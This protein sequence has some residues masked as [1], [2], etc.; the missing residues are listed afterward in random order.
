M[1]G[2][3]LSLSPMVTAIFLGMVFAN[4]VGF[5]ASADAGICVAGKKLLRLAVAMLGLQLTFNQLA[6][7]GITGLMLAATVVVSTL[8]FTVWVGRCE[9]EV[10]GLRTLITSR[11]R[12]L[13]RI[14]G[15]SAP[16][17]GFPS[18]AQLRIVRPRK[19]DRMILQLGRRPELR[20]LCSFFSLAC[21]G[22]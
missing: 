10:P 21:L 1:A 9:G 3:V 11:Q 22:R 16:T 17:A 12:W 18:Q 20:T 14:L 8:I 5:S 15:R 2:C 4:I 19:E 13:M 6:G 7:I